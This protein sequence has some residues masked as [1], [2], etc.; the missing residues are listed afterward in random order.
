[1]GLFQNFRKATR[2]KQNSPAG[3]RSPLTVTA[4]LTGAVVPMKDIPDPAFAEGIL[5]FCVGIEPPEGAGE[6][7]LCSPMDGTVTQCSD[8]TGHAVGITSSDGKT[9]VLL[10]AGIDTVEM[11]GEGFLLH[12]GEGDPVTAGTPVLTM[13]T[14]KIRAAGHPCTVIVIVTETEIPVRCA[15]Q[16]MAQA[17]EILFTAAE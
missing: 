16:E 2:E 15:V 12:V 5:G 1:M 6:V 3:I 13:D 14:E 7:L 17:G 10:H 9:A 11:N 4:P 8:T